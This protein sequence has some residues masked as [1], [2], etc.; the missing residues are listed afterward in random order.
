MMMMTMHAVS[1]HR[2]HQIVRPLLVQFVQVEAGEEHVVLRAHNDG[3]QLAWHA[4]PLLQMVPSP[5]LEVL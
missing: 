3:E 2:R 1:L 4:I 5:T